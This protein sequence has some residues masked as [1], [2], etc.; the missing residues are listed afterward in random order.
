MNQDVDLMVVGAGMAGMTAA[1]KCASRGWRVAI[2]DELPY[3]GTC[4]LRGCDPKKILR[5]G[6]EIIDAAA[7]MRGKGVDD[8][9]L[10]ISWADLMAHKRGFTHPAPA[11]MEAGLALQ[12]VTTLH[13]EARFV[14]ADRVEVDGRTYL[15]RHVLIATG[16]A[17]RPLDLPGAE[18]VVD[19]T[20]FLDLEALPARIVFVGGGFVSFELAHIAARAGSSVVVVDRGPRPLRTFDP[21][22]VELL[23]ARGATVG[24]EVRRATRVEEVRR[25]ASGFEV[26]VRDARGPA[27]IAADLVVHGAGRRPQLDRLDLAAAGVTATSRG[28]SVAP[29]LQSVT[30]PLVWAA[31]DCAETPGMPLTPVAVAEGKVAASNML[32]GTTTVPDHTGSPRRCSPSRSWPAS[33]CCSTRPPRRGST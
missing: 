18:L 25:S 32:K 13:G 8:R 23:V 16:A 27:T 1:E 33:G 2:V 4:A 7:L 29:H 9:G 21:D 24:V 5:R 11:R 19:S 10:S 6:A 17:P 31:G 12:G 15:A 30:N 22:L 26:L 28:V 3:G 20:H 14:G